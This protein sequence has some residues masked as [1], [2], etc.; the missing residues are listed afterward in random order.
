MSRKKKEQ[1]IDWDSIQ[2]EFENTPQSVDQLASKYNVH[3]MLI[4]DRIKDYHWRTFKETQTRQLIHS[5]DLV[6]SLSDLAK[7]KMLAMHKIMEKLHTQLDEDSINISDASRVLT[8]ITGEVTKITK[9]AGIEEIEL[10]QLKG[11]NDTQV[12]IEITPVKQI[13]Q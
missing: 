9:L 2:F 7:S 5:V 11:N 8:N 12:N 4:L 13:K 10:E 6:L 1:I 3:Y